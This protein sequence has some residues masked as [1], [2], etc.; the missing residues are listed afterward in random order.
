M[1]C[2]ACGVEAPT[3]YVAFYQNIGAL[4]M[5]FGKSIQGQL[6]KSC[7]HKYY[8]EFTGITLV[9]GWWGLISF[10]LTPIFLINNAVRYL[11]CLGMPPVPP[12]AKPPRL[13]TDAMERLDSYTQEI[14]DRLHEGQK[15]EEFAEDVALRANVTPAQVA[16]YVRYVY[17]AMRTQRPQPRAEKPS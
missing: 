8:W 9:A 4:V 15:M 5:R 1:I 13:T 16:L 2:Q 10:I 17:D 14:F 12:D 7:I 11:P 6:C 3:R